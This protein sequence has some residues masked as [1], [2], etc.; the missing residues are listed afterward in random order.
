MHRPTAFLAPLLALTLVAGLAAAQPQPF[1]PALNGVRRS[2]EVHI[3]GELLS[4]SVVV[5]GGSDGSRM[6]Q[7]YVP[8]E[9]IA[10]AVNGA[11]LLEPALR[12]DGNRLLL[13]G[14]S[15]SVADK[16]GAKAKFDNKVSTKIADQAQKVEPAVKIDAGSKD[17]A[18]LWLKRADDKIGMKQNVSP[19]LYKWRKDAAGIAVSSTGLISSDVRMFDGKAY[20]PLADVARAFGGEARLG[21]GGYQI[22]VPR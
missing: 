14:V 5:S 16:I 21:N 1:I 9:D 17:A 10:R 8:L 19:S 18:K 7:V 22:S 20:V 11:P 15:G 4:R 12:I 6:E 3:N 13:S 2:S